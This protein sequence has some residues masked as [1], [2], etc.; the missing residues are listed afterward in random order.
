MPTINVNIQPAIIRWAL[1][2]TSEENLG[3]KLMDNIKHWLDS[4]ELMNPNRDLI[5]T[6]HEMEVVQD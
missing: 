5:D 1:S 4:A 3:A 2:Q 6:I